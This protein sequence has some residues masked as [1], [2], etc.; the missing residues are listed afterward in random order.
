MTISPVI[1]YLYDILSRDILYSGIFVLVTFCPWG[2]LSS[3]SL[4]CDIFTG[5]IFFS[6]HDI[7]S[8]DIFPQ[9]VSG[10]WVK[11]VRHEV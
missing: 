2:I 7:W 4:L 10:E 5:D 3:D 1:F 11:I 9:S 8:R 6:V